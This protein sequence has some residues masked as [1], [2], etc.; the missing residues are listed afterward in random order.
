M[1]PRN[2]LLN[3]FAIRC[4]RDTAD[5]DYIHARLAYRA[6]LVPQFRWSALHSLEKY[7][8]CILLL[9]RVKAKGVGHEVSG[10]LKRMK[11]SGPYP[12]SVSQQTDRFIDHLESGAQFRY[13]ELSY[14]NTGRDV[15]KLDRAVWELRRYCQCL[16][17]NIT[18]NGRSIS[19]LDSNL[20]RLKDA[21]S[22]IEKDTCI[23]GGW[24]EQ[25]IKKKEHPAREPLLWQN[26]Y[27]GPSKRKR[28]LFADYFEAGNSP[29]YLHPEI[30]DEVTQ[31]VHLPKEI[32]NLWREELAKLKKN[33]V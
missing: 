7:A 4:F 1:R 8:K 29:L 25:V 22:K 26:L 9:N 19:A 10:S 5:R 13:F 3:D 2:A 16:N 20:Q 15:I 21:V 30:L 11:E 32:K 18:V 12:I 33:Q 28:I 24:L 14:S 17:Y 6:Q 31:Y 23:L 27:F